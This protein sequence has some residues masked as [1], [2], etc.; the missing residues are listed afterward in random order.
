MLKTLKPPALALADIQEFTRETYG[1]TGRWTPLAGERDQNFHVVEDGGDSWTLKMCNPNEGAGMLACQAAALEHIAT[2]A[3]DLA[4]PR[5]RRTLTGEAL[6]SLAAGGRQWP[7]LVLSHLPGEVVGSRVL[8][9]GQLL[10]I[11]SA[12][13]RLGIALRGFINGA[14]A[15]R[16]LIWDTQHAA[17]LDHLIPD[18]PAGDQPLAA[19]VLR[20][21]RDVSLPRLRRL[22]SQI[23]HGD[24]QPHNTLLAADG[25][26]SGFID[27]GDMVHSALIIDLANAAADFL[28]PGFDNERILHA[29]VRG[30]AGIVRLEEEEADLLYD[31]IETRL[32]MA[33]LIE[34]LKARNG[35]LARGYSEAVS[36]RIMNTVRELR[37]LGPQRLRLL[38]RR[39]AAWP[40]PSG[41]FLSAATAIARRRKVMG[42]KPNVFYDPPLHIVKGEGVWLTDS[43]GHRFLD[44]YNNVPH[45]GHCHPYVTEAVVRQSRRLNTNTRYITDQSIDYAERLAALTEPGLT[46]VVFV[47]SGS[48]ANDLA[49]RMAKAWTGRSGGLAMDFAYHG[50][51]E[52]MDAFSP[53]NAPASWQAPHIRLL[54]PPCFYRGTY[55]AGTTNAGEKF[56]AL[57]EA[58]IAELEAAGL[59]VA[60]AIVD[61]AFMTNGILAAPE[62][63]VAGLAARVWRAGG[64]F[65]ADE[66]Q[67]GFGRL[68]GEF[69][70]HRRYGVVPDVITIGKPAGNGYPV[71]A[72]ITRHE[73][74]ECFL[75]SGP[76]FS[77][78]GGNNVACAAGVAVLDVIRDEHLVSRA[79]MVGDHFRRRLQGLKARHELVGD[80]RGVGLALAVELVRNRRTREPADRETQRLLN[81]VRDEGVLFGSEGRFGNVVKIRPP[82]VITAQQ[83]DLAVAA[84]DK[85][86]GR[87]ASEGC[88]G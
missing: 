85:A 50:V 1:L 42:A 78:F 34:T 13:A 4:V 22:R 48:E 60:A 64:L 35:I 86:L 24:V 68:G 43:S 31:L 33:P 21:H 25:A 29:M 36:G 28:A 73:I 67:A 9:A 40:E 32:V 79:E 17:D 80:V 26:L 57:A 51:T 47:N 71:G 59:G 6:P 8:E 82:I 75:K 69:W 66:V 83:A 77:T 54:P 16:H 18:L 52:A 10:A 62:G 38:L 3:P 11:A 30:Y 70:G 81:L 65:I 12:L 58:P 41:V 46:A 27:F 72:V 88:R 45:V 76:F 23:I 44:C 37:G 55:P 61:S 49:W 5:L 87:L 15:G 14:P 2:T 56:A 74:L 20:R 53:S 63:Y 7:A 39:A 84:L 19:E